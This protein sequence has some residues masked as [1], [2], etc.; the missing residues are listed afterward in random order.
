MLLGGAIGNLIDRLFTA[1]REV[2]DFISLHISLNQQTH[3][4]PTFNVADIGIVLGAICV[5]YY[6]YVIEKRRA[7]TDQ[8]H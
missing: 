6:V 1:N 5:L 7:E 3:T 4:W 8:Q 2:T